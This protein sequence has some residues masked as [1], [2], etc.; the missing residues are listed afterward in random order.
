M[1]IG[2]PQRFGKHVR[3]LR[4]ARELTQESLAEKSG[5]S[6]DAVARVESGRM[7][8]TL[9]TLSKLADGLDLS[10]ATLF[11]TFEREGR[12][13]ASEVA[14]YLARRTAKEVRMARRVMRA[15]FEE[16]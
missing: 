8:P 12:K 2:L 5:L 1:P 4:G 10:L 7:V 16:R 6:V 15:M 3:A 13:D 14:D 11:E 9:T